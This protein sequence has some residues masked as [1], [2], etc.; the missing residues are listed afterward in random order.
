MIYLWL[1][2]KRL[3]SLVESVELLVENVCSQ[4]IEVLRARFESESVADNRKD[5]SALLNLGLE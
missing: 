1:N 5:I 2:L 4:V 3:P